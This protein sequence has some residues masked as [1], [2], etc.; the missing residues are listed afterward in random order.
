[1]PPCALAV[2]ASNCNRSSART[3]VA[4]LVD[5]DD[6]NVVYKE[7]SQIGARRLNETTSTKTPLATRVMAG[8]AGRLK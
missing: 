1:M 8:P 7:N 3:V 2:S 5:A 6:E 4:R